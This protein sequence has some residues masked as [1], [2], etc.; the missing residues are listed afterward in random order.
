MEIPDEQSD[1]ANFLWSLEPL[2]K[3]LHC[4]GIPLTFRNGPP[5]KVFIVLVSLLGCGIILANLVINGPRCFES[6]SFKWMDDI[7]NFD[8]PFT[9]FER[10]P[11]GIVK[12]LKI[13]SDMVFFL[14]VPFMHT[15]F[16]ATLL[17]D[18]NWKKLLVILE[19][20]RHE[21]K[22]NDEFYKKCRRQCYWGIF[23][24]ILVLIAILTCISR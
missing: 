2:T 11:F 10:N 4:L 24:L 14:Y 9:Y 21:M 19:K 1:D 6:G 12:L 13:I 22:L 18:Q 23:I 16:V 5:H 7:Q 20:I 17:F 8:S 3:S 15:A